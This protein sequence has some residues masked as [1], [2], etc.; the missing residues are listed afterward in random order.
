[1]PPDTNNDDDASDSESG[2]E[3]KDTGDTCSK[4]GYNGDHLVVDGELIYCGRCKTD[5]TDQL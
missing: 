1:M 5:I 4:C 3:W 2:S